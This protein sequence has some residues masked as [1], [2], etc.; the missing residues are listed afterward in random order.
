M[1]L[2]M[3]PLALPL[4]AQEDKQNEEFDWNPVID[5][6]IEIESR[7]N[8][9]TRNGIYVGVLQISPVLVRECNNILK[10]RGDSR[11]F[12]LNDRLSREK[13]KEMFVVVMSR[14]NPENDIDKAA[15]IWKMGI[16]YTI[17]GSQQFVNRVR[18]IMKRNQKEKEK[19]ANAECKN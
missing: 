5:A 12:T 1:L 14:F 10:S 16:H 2:L 13:S 8:E 3:L 17:K 15:R 7:G 19:N 9:R 4:M 11:R 18:S 6:I